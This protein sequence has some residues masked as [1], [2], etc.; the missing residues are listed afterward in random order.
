M[1]MACRYCP[2]R[3]GQDLIKD[4][5]RRENLTRVLLQLQD[6]A[7]PSKELL[8]ALETGQFEA[9]FPILTRSILAS[10]SHQNDWVEDL[11]RLDL[12]TSIAEISDYLPRVPISKVWLVG[13]CSAWGFRQRSI[14][15]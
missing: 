11:G 9:V 7:V 4:L 1:G 6:N 13:F 3:G 10:V 5:R 15:H 2:R 14:K 8:L 12:L